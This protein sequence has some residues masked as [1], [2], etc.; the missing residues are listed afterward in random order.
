MDAPEIRYATYT[1]TVLVSGNYVN[2]EIDGASVQGSLDYMSDRFKE[3]YDNH[4]L[5]ITGWLFGS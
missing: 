3:Q 2:V 5:T 4:V 1:G